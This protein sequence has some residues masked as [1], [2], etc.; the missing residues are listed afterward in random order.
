M[1][2]TSSKAM[3]Q[4]LARTSACELG[5]QLFEAWRVSSTGL[6]SYLPSRAVTGRRIRPSGPASTRLSW[7]SGC[8]GV[9]ASEPNTSELWRTSH[10][11]GWTGERQGPRVKA[12]GARQQPVRRGRRPAAQPR[13]SQRKRRHHEHEACGT[14]AHQ[15]RNPTPF[16]AE[17][18]N[19]PGRHHLPDR[20]M[21]RRGRDARCR[22]DHLGSMGGDRGAVTSSNSGQHKHERRER[23]YL[24]L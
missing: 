22:G 13:P 24:V 10:I 6:A 2:L 8:G 7:C 21:L 1:A 12:I 15:R 9:D 19:H 17:Q 23:A 3:W 5:R 14:E 4:R 16:E 11:G 18:R 20:I